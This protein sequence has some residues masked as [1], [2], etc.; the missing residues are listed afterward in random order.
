MNQ[1]E[2]NIDFHEA[3]PPPSGSFYYYTHIPDFHSMYRKGQS[4]MSMFEMKC[5]KW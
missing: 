3:T 2:Q 5:F 4:K 1:K